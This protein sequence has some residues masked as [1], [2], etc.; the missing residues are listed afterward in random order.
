MKRLICSENILTDCTFSY[1]K[2]F[3]ETMIII[4]YDNLYNKMIPDVFVT[5]NNKNQEGYKA[6]FK[7][8][9]YKFFIHYK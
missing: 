2:D 5:V 3:Y 9:K 1:P 7:S 6:I 8:L 4:F